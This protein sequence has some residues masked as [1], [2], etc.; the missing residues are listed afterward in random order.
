MIKRLMLWTAVAAM[1]AAFTAA[2]QTQTVVP[3]PTITDPNPGAELVSTQPTFE[4]QPVAGAVSYEFSLAEDATFESVVYSATVT[5]NR[6]SLTTTLKR[7]K[8]YHFRVR[9]TAAAGTGD[10]A[11]GFFTTA[12][13]PAAVVPDEPPEVVVEIPDPIVIPP[14]EVIVTPEVIV[15]INEV[16]VEIPAEVVFTVLTPAPGGANVSVR[17]I[18]SWSAVNG[19]TGYEFILAVE[20]G[21]DY[22]FSVIDYSGTLVGTRCVVSEDLEYSTTYNWGVRALSAAGAGQ[23]VIASFTTEAEPGP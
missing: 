7:G 21:A 23:W 4:W 22:P 19:A 12:A 2:C 1:L 18:F 20:T 9:A 8:L 14:P 16:I 11:T 10:W 15:E 5:V 6:H 3:S 17:P 13:E